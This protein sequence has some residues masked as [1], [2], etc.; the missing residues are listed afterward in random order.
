MTRRV[1]IMGAAGRDFHNFNVFYRDNPD[2]DVVAFTATQIPFIDERKYPAELAGPRYPVPYGD[3][4]AQRVQRFETFDDL[5]KHHVTLEEREEYEP[6]L[7]NDTVVYAGVDYGAILEQ[8]Q[9]EADVVVWDG[10]NND[11]PFYRPTV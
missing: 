9:Q 10:G 6:H 1:L 11:Y 8:A 3:L 5:T 2:R 4:V 7:H